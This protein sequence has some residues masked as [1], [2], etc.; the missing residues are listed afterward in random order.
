M[1]GKDQTG[2]KAVEVMTSLLLKKETI[3]LLSYSLFEE[4]VIPPLTAR[5]LQHLKIYFLPR[6]ESFATL[7]TRNFTTFLAGILI[8]SPV[9]GFL[10]V[11]AFR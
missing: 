7:A 8:G 5:T 3:I 11:R 6:M 2:E 10:P 1:E 4:E 9:W